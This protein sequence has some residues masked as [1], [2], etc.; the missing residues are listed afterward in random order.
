MHQPK[1]EHLETSMVRRE[2]NQ[3]PEPHVLAAQVPAGH[4]SADGQ[5]P[6]RFAGVGCTSL[7]TGV[8]RC[9]RKISGNVGASG[10]PPAA[11]GEPF[12]HPRADDPGRNIPGLCQRVPAGRHAGEGYAG[13]RPCLRKESVFPVSL[14]AAA[15]LISAKG[16]QA[17]LP[18]SD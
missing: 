13:D 9:H 5:Q 16:S 8:R 17:L 10:S 15:A 1:S 18:I 3:I 2:R 6:Y 7:C 12:I 4:A 14:S 11:T